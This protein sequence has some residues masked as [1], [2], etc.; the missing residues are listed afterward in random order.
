MGIP[1]DTP[2]ELEKSEVN[3]ESISNF[4]L[5]DLDP[6]RRKD[7]QILDIQK[8]L[9][10]YEYKNIKSTNHPSLIG[11]ADI[12]RNSFSTSFDFLSQSKVWYQG[13]LIGLKLQIPIFDGFAVKS[14][15]AQSKVRQQQLLIDRDQA[16]DAA[17]MEYN[18]ATKKYFNALQTLRANEENLILAEDVLKET[19][20]LFKEGLSPLT[21]LLEAES[22]QRQAKANYNNQL[23]QV[24][25]A[26]LE[27]LK[28]SGQIT[29]IIS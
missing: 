25:I 12:N 5:A 27:I 2:L 26:Q 29:R 18:N 13:S 21:D 8:T 15:A 10:D 19:T 16:M 3:P 28:S 24:R 4:Q 1:V 20:L 9:Y 7:I 11:F 6:E 14:R 17:K 23:I 22:T